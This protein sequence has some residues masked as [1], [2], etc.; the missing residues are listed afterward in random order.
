VDGLWS[1]YVLEAI[2]DNGNALANFRGIDL[3]DLLD[4]QI[5]VFLIDVNRKLFEGGSQLVSELIVVHLQ[6][7]D[8][9]LFQHIQ[10]A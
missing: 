8:L 2:G 9:Q 7:F 6:P 3:L 10:P 5:K 4:K 1:C